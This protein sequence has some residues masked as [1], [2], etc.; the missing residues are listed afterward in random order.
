VVASRR[1]GFKVARE[2]EE[3]NRTGMALSESSM[4][5][6]CALHGEVIKPAEACHIPK[7]RPR[8]LL[9]GLAG[10]VDCS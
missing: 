10:P 5:G 8:R 9:F 3:L 4:A 2:L 7:T 1:A 6:H